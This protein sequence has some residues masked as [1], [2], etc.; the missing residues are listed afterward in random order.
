MTSTIYSRFRYSSD[1]NLQ[2]TGE[3]S[4]GEV[5]DYVLSL[6][7]YDYGDLP[8]GSVPA[9]PDYPTQNADDGARHIIVT[10]GSGNP[11][12][13]SVVDAEVDGQPDA[14]ATGDDLAGSSDEDGVT[15]PSVLIADPATPTTIYVDMTGSTYDGL[16]SAWIDF[17]QDGSWDDA[18]EQIY[19]NELVEAGDVRTLPAL[20]VPKIAAW[21]YLPGAKVT[22]APTMPLASPPTL[23]I[24]SPSN[25]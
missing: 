16:L 3:A 6:V 25:S 15:L 11:T 13:G 21:P 24:A 17:D 4:N 10:D 12:L 18:G 23:S 20:T 7:P 2:P 19:A 1:S 22:L 8:D 14:T 9:T 5:E